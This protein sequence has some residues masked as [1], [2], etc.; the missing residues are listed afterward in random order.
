MSKNFKV[1]IVDDIVEVVNTIEKQLNKL[2]ETLS[3]NIT[4]YKAYNILD[5]IDK[6]EDEDIDIFFIDYDFK[7]GLDGYDF[8]KEINH[9]YKNK[10]MILMTSHD[11]LANLPE[12]L[13]QSHKESKNNQF[14]FYTKPL[15]EL[16]IHD[17]LIKSLEYISKINN[18]NINL[19]IIIEKLPFPLSSILWRYNIEDN[20]L[21][22]LF[23]YFEA[24]SKYLSIIILS[25]FIKNEEFYNQNKN[26]IKSNKKWYERP[27]F[28]NWNKC[29]K[30]Y[31]DILNNSELNSIPNNLELFITNKELLIDLNKIA[32]L[33]N[34][35]KGHGGFA[36][37]E[38]VQER[39][40]TLEIYLQEIN[41]KLVKAFED[42][43]LIKGDSCI[44]TRTIKKNTVFNLNGIVT[45][46]SKQI[47]ESKEIFN[48]ETLYLC[49]L[50]DSTSIPLLPLI[51]FIE[52][53]EGCFFYN[54]VIKNGTKIEAKFVSYHYDKK[55]EYFCDDEYVL[56]NVEKL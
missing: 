21:E 33:R 45:P 25:Y 28:G 53:N 4:I 47:I 42:L 14:L 39:V 17:I 2:M 20:K 24:V 50:K 32:E 36:G 16:T 8:I 5:A 12:I 40:K 56:E 30:R 13:K 38:E 15:K 52:N 1:L 37:E 6:T 31:S 49:N 23:N 3:I 54:G 22:H 35:W 11:E 19:E 43:L 26:T 10:F 34:N 7:G 18:E 51:E 55:S 29:I 44:S 41:K 48:T 9:K 46:F 27:T